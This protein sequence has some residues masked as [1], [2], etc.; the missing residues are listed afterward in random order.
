MNRLNF[1]KAG[2]M[3]LVLCAAVT[4]SCKKDKNESEPTPIAV[5]GVTLNKTT[6]TLTLGASE[7]LTANVA[8]ADAAN[9]AVAWA[10]SNAAVATVSNNGEV[11]AVSAG[12]ATITV[13]TA[14]GGKTAT[15]AVTVTAATVAV[16][17]VTLDK[18]TLPL[19]V[20]DTEALTATVAPADATNKALAWSSSNAVVATVTGGTVTALSMG[21][22]TITVTTDDGA[23]TATCAVTVKV[24]TPPN[25]ATDNVW[26]IG[27]GDDQQIWSDVIELPACNKTDFDGG[28]NSDP[29]ADCRKNADD[30]RGYYY[31]WNYVNE[32]AAELCPA[33]W[34]VPTL[35]DFT[36]LDQLLGGDG[37]SCASGCEALVDD[38]VNVWG[39]AKLGNSSVG[40]LANVGTWGEYWS[41]DVSAGFS[42]NCLS[43][44]GGRTYP[45]NATYMRVG[46]P[47]RCVK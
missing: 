22:A 39:G 14:D 38:Y 33:G 40:T 45:Q 9:K 21:T 3:A 46:M 2:A 4:M 1:L 15:C 6:L 7:T 47:V 5:T 11:T 44:T 31:S 17:G 25:A 30:Y 20:G 42:S 23:K 37:K 36:I 32:H 29:L 27:E 34:R 12:A 35:A 16:S 13:T 8:P 41:A 19:Y 10:S 26:I 43:Y 18:T 28:T 24:A